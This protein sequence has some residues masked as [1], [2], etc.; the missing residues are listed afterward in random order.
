MVVGDAFEIGVLRAESG[1]EETER[2]NERRAPL[3]E[4]SRTGEDD[5]GS[6]A[7]IGAVKSSWPLTFG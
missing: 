1:R 4:R 3:L 7:S 5:Y 6:T 2:G